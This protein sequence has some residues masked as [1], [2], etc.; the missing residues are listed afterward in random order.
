[1]ERDELLSPD[2]VRSAADPDRLDEIG[3]DYDPSD[4]SQHFDYWLKRLQV[5]CITPWLRGARTL[6]LGCA[7]GELTSLLEPLVDRY[8]VVEGSPHNVE[9]ASARV[10]RANFTLSMWE[11]FEPQACYSDIVLCNAI[12]HVQDPRSL[13][14]RARDWLEPD[15]RIH[16][17]VPNGHSLHRLVGVELGFLPE[18]LHLSDGDRSQGHLRNYTVDSLLAEVRGAGL[19]VAHLQPVFLKVLSNPQML[20]WSRELIEAMHT[21]AQRF[22]EHGAEI[23]AVAERA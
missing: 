19:R 16:I 12:E 9:V 8:D 5:Q 1:V 7:T 18:P 20:S 23:Y 14:V 4:P 21:V 13:L 3:R 10:P 2:P 22:P 15:G 11:D 17:V 6:E